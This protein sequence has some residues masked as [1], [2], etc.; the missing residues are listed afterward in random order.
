MSRPAAAGSFVAVAPLRPSGLPA[1]QPDG[2]IPDIVLE[3][4][5]MSPILD[6]LH[7]YDGLAIPEVWLWKEGACEL[8]RRNPEGGYARITKSTYLT[9]TTMTSAQ[10]TNEA[11]PKTLAAVTLRPFS[12]LKHCWMA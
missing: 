1:A 2:E 8:Y 12:S 9:V 7:V 10:I 3:V 4:I 5:H 6:K 11:M